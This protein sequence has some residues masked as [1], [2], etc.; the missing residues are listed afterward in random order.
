MPTNTNQMNYNYNKHLYVLDVSYVKTELGLDFIDKE[1]SLTRAKDKM[2]LCSK[3]VYEYIYKHTT[4]RKY[5]E[6]RLAFDESLRQVIQE[7]LELQARYEFDMDAQ[8]LSY[9]NG[10]NLQ[11]GVVVNYDKFRGELRVAPLV[12]DVLR[13]EKLLFSGQ[14]FRLPTSYDYETLGY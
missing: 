8:Y 1:G 4:Y 2:Y 6:Y 10:V 5:M 14:Q 7:C 3:E 12:V 13:G 9:Q 11:N